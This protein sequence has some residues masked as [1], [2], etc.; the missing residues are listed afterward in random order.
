VTSLAASGVL[1]LEF[2]NYRS[3]AFADDLHLS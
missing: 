2:G 3:H 1:S